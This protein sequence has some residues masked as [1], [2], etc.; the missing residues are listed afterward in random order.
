MNK[1]DR[2]ARE[3]LVDRFTQ[4]ILMLRHI[5][6]SEEPDSVYQMH[7]AE[8]KKLREELITGK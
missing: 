4:L 3:K 8:Y 1:K 2:E 6:H 5:K 7:Y